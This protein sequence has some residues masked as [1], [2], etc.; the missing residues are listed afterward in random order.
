MTK[1]V[2]IPIENFE[3]EGRILYVP[4]YHCNNPN[5]Y[6]IKMTQDI[7]ASKLEF[8][9]P[10]Y[11][12]ITDSP[13]PEKVNNIYPDPYNEIR[14][15]TV[16][17]ILLPR[18]LREETKKRIDTPNRSYDI[19]HRMDD[20]RLRNLI[21]IG[22]EHDMQ[23]KKDYAELC[24]KYGEVN[25]ALKNKEQEVSSSKEE[26]QKIKYAIFQN[27]SPEVV[28]LRIALFKKLSGKSTRDWLLFLKRL[29][30]S[31]PEGYA[32]Y[33]QNN[34]PHNERELIEKVIKNPNQFKAMFD[35]APKNEDQLR[36]IFDR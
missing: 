36:K 29:E 9:G 35:G 11:L 23:T 31:F 26:L 12:I 16:D 25:Q 28:D 33:I 19:H 30:D 2:S 3:K 18:F 21:R 24:R 20:F 34:I 1:R 6:K 15:V 32:V 17:G 8:G 13:E 5:R 27:R 10:K 4:R 14:H 7:L 22:L